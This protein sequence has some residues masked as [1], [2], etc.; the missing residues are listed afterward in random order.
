VLTFLLE[1]V[2]TIG[3]TMLCTQ[4]VEVGKMK[5]LESAELSK[6]V[7]EERARLKM[8]QNLYEQGMN[9]LHHHQVNQTVCNTLSLSQ[10]ARTVIY[11][12]SSTSSR[13]TRLLRYSINKLYWSYIRRIACS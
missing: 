2:S 3:A 4:S 7:S 11:S 5:E 6:K 10:S 12:A 9:C 1:L 13:R 8:Q